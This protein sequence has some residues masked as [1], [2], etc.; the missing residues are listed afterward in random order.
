HRDGGGRRVA[1]GADVHEDLG[2]RQTETPRRRIDDADVGL[3]GNEQ[4]DVVHVQTGLAQGSGRGFSHRGDGP[5]ED[6]GTVHTNPPVLGAAG[7]G[8]AGT[9][10]LR[11]PEDVPHGSVHAQFGRQQADGSVGGLHHHGAGGVTEQHRGGPVGEVE[12]IVELLGP[13]HQDGATGPGGDHVGSDHHRIHEAGA[14]GVEVESCG[15]VS[16]ELVLEDGGGR[17]DER[18]G[19]TSGEDDQVYV[20]DVPTRRG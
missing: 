9:S 2:I 12:V 15:P 19:G 11:H 14:G 13:D 4:V 7:P 3:V 16:A 8:R 5:P 20:V 1:V 18:V 6:L 10:V 17:G